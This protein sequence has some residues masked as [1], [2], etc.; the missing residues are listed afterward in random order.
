MG[1]F[2]RRKPAESSKASADVTDPLLRDAQLR[3]DA[4]LEKRTAMFRGA[5][6]A[7]DEVQCT[8]HWGSA[9]ELALL[10][11][12]DVGLRPERLRRAWQAADWKDRGAVLRRVL[13]QLASDLAD[14]ESESFRCMDDIGLAFA[15]ARWSEWPPQQVAAVREFMDA[16]WIRS[17]A[18]PD[19]QAGD[20]L[21]F[22]VEA[23]GEPSPWL[24]AW[25][26]L[27]HPAADR[28]LVE[29]VD[30]WRVALRIH[31][32]PW[33]STHDEDEVLAV[34]TTWLAGLSDHRRTG[35]HRHDE[36]A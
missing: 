10:K 7:P 31:E 14:R 27:D 18:T 24:D 15:R 9:E 19:G 17:L 3:L 8:C 29:A 34:L 26:A 33:V 11:V 2:V 32:L 12:P 5:V 21:A 30:R 1:S 13:P 36:T 23:S 6:A 25:K 4:A 16:F 22:C 28:N 20:V 35:L